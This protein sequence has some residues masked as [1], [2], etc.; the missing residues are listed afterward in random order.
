VFVLFM[1]LP[2]R[3]FLERYAELASGVALEAPPAQLEERHSPDAP[4]LLQERPSGPDT[5]G[6]WHRVFDASSG[7]WYYH[8][9]STLVVSWEC[10]A[11]WGTTETQQASGGAGG[12]FYADLQGVTQGPFSTEQL[13]G[14]RAVLPLEL[15]V[16]H[17]AEGS[18]AA[19]AVPLAQ[20][21][22]DVQLLTL[23]R[24]GQLPLPPNATAA[25]AEAVLSATEAAANAAGGDT[26]WAAHE[27]AQSGGA[28]GGASRA[29]GPPSHF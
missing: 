10:P 2:A 20:V 8:N 15:R 12:W 25:H 5:W 14:W 7:R 22:G 21:T 6:S 23:L 28:G 27:A 19:Q 24:S 13:T 29:W 3:M 17:Q 9:T 11:G 1:W 18:A 16:W 4:L 26:W